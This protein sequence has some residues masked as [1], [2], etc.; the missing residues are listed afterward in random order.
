[1]A[2]SWLSG[3]RHLEKIPKIRS[4]TFQ[5]AGGGGGEAPQPG[6]GPAK[7]AGERG[8]P[9]M[10]TSFTDL[11]SGSSSTCTVGRKNTYLLSRL[12]RL[13]DPDRR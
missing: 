11:S 4:S 13:Q 1:M 3:G 2:C 9:R 7:G 12:L 6:A 10:K 8:S 5:P